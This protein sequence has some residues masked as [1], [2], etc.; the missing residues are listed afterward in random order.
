MTLTL[1][2]CDDAKHEG[3]GKYSTIKGGSFGR[4]PI[5]AV[6]RK[7]LLVGMFDASGRLLEFEN[8]KGNPYCECDIEDDG[9]KD[10]RQG[11]C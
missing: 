10:D 3:Y 2:K 8:S 6:V 7:G 5:V 11:S 1:Y 9:S 4:K